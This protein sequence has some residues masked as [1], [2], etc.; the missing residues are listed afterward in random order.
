MLGIL[1][2]NSETD[3][4][5][6]TG[7]SGEHS[8]YNQAKQTCRVMGRHVSRKPDLERDFIN[9]VHSFPELPDTPN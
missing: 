4:I 2:Q 3:Q 9:P 1:S 7:Y 5:T 6:L 8:P